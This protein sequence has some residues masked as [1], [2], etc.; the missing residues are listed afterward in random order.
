MNTKEFIHYSYSDN[1]ILTPITE[2]SLF[3]PV[4]L[5]LANGNDWMDASDEMGIGT[6][7]YRYKII[8]DMSNIIIID[9]I[10]KLIEFVEKY[11]S[12]YYG[13][14]W[15]RVSEIYKG[16]YVTNYQRI[17]QMLSMRHMINFEYTWFFALDISSCCVTDISCVLSVEKLF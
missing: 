5:W 1:L 13:F 2:S 14:D 6:S 4:G 7:N 15:K 12:S 10:E 3:K 9:D 17:K 8:V 16:I 11:K